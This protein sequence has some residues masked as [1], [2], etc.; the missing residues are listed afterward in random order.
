[1]GHVP[2]NLA[3]SVSEA[4]LQ[5]SL[6]GIGYS[7]F[8][9]IVQHQ[10]YLQ[11]TLQ[12]QK[13]LQV[14][15][16]QQNGDLQATLQQQ[17]G[18]LQ[19]IK[20]HYEAAG[21]DHSIT[22]ELTDY[23]K[24]MNSN[25]FYSSP[26]F[27]TSSNGYN[28]IVQVLPNGYGRN[29]GSYVLVC[30]SILKGKYDNNLNWPFIESFTFELLNQLEDRNHHSKVRHFTSSDNVTL[31]GNTCWAIFQFYSI[32]SLLY[33]S[34]S[35]TQYLKD[36]TLYFRVSA[37]A[38]GHRPWLECNEVE[39]KDVV[40]TFKLP[41][42]KEKKASGNKI[43][44]SPSFYSSPNGYRMKIEVY[45]NGNGDGEGT[46]VSVYLLIISGENDDELNW[47]FVGLISIE[48]LNQLRDKNH[49][50]DY[51]HIFPDFNGDNYSLQ[52]YIPHSYLES[53]SPYL[54]D[55][56]LYFRVSVNM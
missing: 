52:H 28:M 13:Y 6:R 3:P 9:E 19:A 39:E 30:A 38:S 18:D 56:T 53:N 45:A 42:Y 2:Y 31:S 24:K 50:S 55:N 49:H 54:Q 41:D 14:T 22:F 40:T 7:L 46:H 48:L 16:Q 43:F 35:T 37:Q 11:A 15:L 36:D 32:Y 21:H 17:N 12:H 25:V 5:Q 47:P 26:P 34:N 44:T 1:M 4:R 51:I 20:H 8:H 10:K 27:Y 23:R 33:E 29:E